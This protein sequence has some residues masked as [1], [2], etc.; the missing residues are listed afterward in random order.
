MNKHILTGLLF[1]CSGTIIWLITPYMISSIGFLAACCTTFS[2]I[3]QVLHTLRTRDTSGISL[4]MYL[5]FVFGVMC[6]LIY[7]LHIQDTPVVLANAV[8]LMLAGIVLALKLQEKKP[9]AVENEVE[10]EVTQKDR[11]A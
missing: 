11:A 4:K 5:M 9:A 6:W 1:L 7:G 3:P 10:T 2:F 8:T